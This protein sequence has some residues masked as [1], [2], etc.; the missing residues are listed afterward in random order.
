MSKGFERPTTRAFA[1]VAGYHRSRN[2]VGL[3]AATLQGSLRA[4]R[5]MQRREP[6]YAQHELSPRP[7]TRRVFDV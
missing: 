1:C 2:A 7:F 6:W 4:I 5:G 3:T